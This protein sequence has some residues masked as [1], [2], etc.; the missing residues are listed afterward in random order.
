[1]SVTVWV[2]APVTATVPGTA[3]ALVTAPI[4]GSGRARPPSE[5]EPA[6]TRRV[7]PFVPRT[8]GSIR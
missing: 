7:E 6:F 4:A 1:M 2:I 5:T 8:D 3:A